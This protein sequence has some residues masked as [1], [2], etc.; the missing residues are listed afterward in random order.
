MKNVQPS[1]LGAIGETPMIRL[2][3]FGA[4]V[5]PTLL[6]KLEFTN[7]G[8]SMKDRVALGMVEWAERELALQPKGEII[9]CT[10]GNLGLG[11]AMVCAVKGY[12]LTCQSLHRA[13]YATTRGR[14]D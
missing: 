2:E 1:V 4:T 13:K 12:R 9:A 11:M 6:A 14:V 7:P 3:R 8:G 5:E 10:S